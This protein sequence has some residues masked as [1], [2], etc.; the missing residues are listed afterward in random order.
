MLC[1]EN[2]KFSKIASKYN[3]KLFKLKNKISTHIICYKLQKQFI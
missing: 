3:A 1:N 2:R